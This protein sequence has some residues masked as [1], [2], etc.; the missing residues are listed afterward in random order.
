VAGPDGIVITN[1]HMIRGAYSEKAVFQDG[2]TADVL[3]VLG[4]SSAE[5]LAAIRLNASSAEPLELGDSDLVEVGDKVV[6]IGSPSAFK[7]RF[8]MVGERLARRT[9]SNQRT[10]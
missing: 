9:N 7:T 5:D 10:D 1:Y 6:A 8:Q 2:S 3:G 4:Y